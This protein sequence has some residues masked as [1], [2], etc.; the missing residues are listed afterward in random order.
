MYNVFD[1]KAVTKHS[2]FGC[3]GTHDVLTCPETGDKII[4]WQAGVN[5]FLTRYMDNLPDHRHLIVA[6]DMGQDYRQ[7]FFADYKKKTEAELAKVNKLEVEQIH[8]MREWLKSFFAALG[9]TQLGVKG[10]EADDVIA[11][12]C[13]GQEVSAMVHTVD[14]D[15]LQ[16]VSDS[17]AVSLKGEIYFNG[18]EYKDYPTNITSV[19]KSIVG[20]PSDK[21]K[22]IPG[23]GPGAITKLKVVLGNYGIKN[24]E[25]IV[26]T[27][28]FS[29]LEA[30]AERHPESKEIAKL[31][32]NW[33]VW[34]DQWRLAKLHPELCW[35]PRGRK[36]V[37]P[38]IHKR[39][40]S[41]QRVYNLLKEI[42]AQDLWANRYSKMIHGVLAVD[43]KVWIENKGKIYE[44]LGKADTISFD[45]ESSDKTQIESFRL[46]ST[47]NFVDTLSQEI[48]G[49]SF[50]FGEHLQNVIYISIDHKGADNVPLSELKELMEHLQN[51]GKQ[52]VAHNAFFEGVLT[53]K[54]LGVRMDDVL[55]TRILQRYYDE[56]SSAGLKSMSLQYLNYEQDSY[57][58][59]L[60]TASAENFRDALNLATGDNYTLAEVL[61]TEAEWDEAQLQL[62]EQTKVTMM[63]QLTLAQVLKYGADD[64]IVTAH[65][66]DL[67]ILLVKLDQQW[68]HVAKW[69]VNPTMT[70]QSAYLHGVTINWA[71]QKRLHTQDLLTMEVEMVKLRKILEENV[72]GTPTAGYES[73]VS[74]ESKYMEQ[75]L[76]DKD[77]ETW[78]PKYNLWK[79]KLKEACNYQPFEVIEI[80]PEFAFTPK[81]LTAAAEAVGLPA[82]EKTTLKFFGEYFEELGLTRDESPEYEGEQG[83]FLKL[84]QA[85][86]ANRVDKLKTEET[87]LRKK[88]FDA[89][90]EFCLRVSKVEPR[91]V[92]VG[93]ELNV[94]S[95]NQMRELL[96]C[97][98]GVPV[99]LFGTTVGLGRLKYGIRQAGPSTDEKAIQ[100]ALALD[101]TED[102]VRD[103][104]TCLLKIKSANTRVSLFHNKMPLWKHT[105]GRIHPSIMDS[106]TDTRRPTGS[107][108]NVLQIPAR[109]EGREMRSMYM[110]PNPDYVCVAIDFSGQELRILACISQD[111]KMLEAYAAGNEK[112]IHSMT[113]MGIAIS[114]ATKDASLQPITVFE[115]FD[116]ARKKEDHPLH[117][118][119]D[120]IRGKKA[121]GVNFGLAYGAGPHTL[122]RNL[123]VPLSEAETLLGGA[124]SLYRRIKPWQDESAEFMN[125]NGFT[126]TAF[127]TK[128]HATDDLFSQDKGKVSRQH[129]QG[130]NAEIQG[131]AAECLKTILTS[132]HTEGWLYKLRMEF[133]APIYDEIVSWVHKDD[134][135]EYCMAMQRL[136]TEA[137]PPGHEVPQIPEFS[138]GADWG[139]CHELGRN[140]QPEAI[141]EMVAR[142]TE[143]GRKVWETDMKMTFEEVYAA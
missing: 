102:W 89:L 3:R 59:T 116:L 29:S 12:V 23:M 88:A 40:P 62:R 7:A 112:D 127:G 19:M 97:K 95:A 47:A 106:G 15:L 25:T 76:K 123:I 37:K 90:A 109:G 41:A 16:L 120:F 2:Y 100:T 6:H 99:R 51:S 94:G 80:M 92:K 67:M 71:L 22:G 83:E 79:D 68:T 93:D 129:R 133:F 4:S 39:V 42:G 34:L 53:Q 11:W 54:E 73:F 118:I 117:A 74:E 17:V 135:V 142:V 24:L 113:G 131:T 63:C 18:M 143:E 96:Y 21:Y 77:K 5:D 82:I 126:L 105:D 139:S 103:A 119:A 104:L 75:L 107:A 128:R 86:V 85:G 9:V 20:D 31:K 132:L 49:V 50:C 33:G 138:I 81:Q 125:R 28:D 45:Y 65:L 48:S 1:F 140:P 72:T 52:M 108:P 36:L 130:A 114:M 124:L 98:I 110:P 111:P 35:K 70:I 58:G 141:I 43:H 78:F 122:S 60:R 91:I 14:A 57:S 32:E 84:L 134:V 44:E 30:L 137:T 121:K 26:D 13:A 115:E 27:K 46:A 61:D 64:A 69:A 38:V 101:V 55:D 56:N 87:F 136:M 66:A 8:K 10:V